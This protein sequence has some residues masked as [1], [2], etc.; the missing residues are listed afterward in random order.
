[1][2]IFGLIKNPLVIAGIIA[3]AIVI[4]V[5]VSNSREPPQPDFVADP[6]EGYAPLEV[7]FIDESTGDVNSWR[8]DFNSDGMVDSTGQNPSNTYDNPGTYTVSLS[9][10]GEEVDWITETKTN[11]IS[12]LASLS[13]SGPTENMTP[14]PPQFNI[15]AIATGPTANITH[16]PSALGPAEFEPSQGTENITHGPSGISPLE[17]IQLQ[18]EFVGTPRYGNEPLEVQFTGYSTASSAQWQWDFDNDGIPDSTEQQ[19]VYVYLNP[20]IY[21]VSVTVSDMEGNTE[22]KTE[23]DYIVVLSSP[24]ADFYS[25]KTYGNAPHEVHFTDNSTGDINFWNWD[26]DGD[27]NVDSW[28]QNPSYIYTEAGK[29]TVSLTVGELISDM[30]TKVDYITVLDPR[31]NGG[32]GGGGN[33][34][35]EVPEEP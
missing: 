16:G 34:G 21:T 7:Q 25:S 29:Y 18:A 20:G 4:P 30:E 17:W 5:A 28:E 10:P 6:I 14:P 9:V 3:A 27:G 1:M 35:G 11:Y 24:Q 19:P 26:F 12:V 8:W 33:G 15:P 13:A 22:T 31:G 23:T 32:G 2:G